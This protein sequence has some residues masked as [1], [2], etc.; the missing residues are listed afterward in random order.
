VVIKK[1][2]F[3]SSTAPAAGDSDH[4]NWKA[5]KAMLVLIPLLGFTYLITIAGPTDKLSLAYYVFNHVRALLLSIQGFAVTLPYCFLN[6]EIKN[7]VRSRWARFQTARSSAAAIDRNARRSTRNSLQ[8]YNYTQNNHTTVTELGNSR[9]SSALTNC[10]TTP[11]GS[12]G[13]GLHGLQPPPS[14]RPGSLASQSQISNRSSFTPE[15]PPPANQKSSETTFIE[16]TVPPPSASAVSRETAG[17]S[18]KKPPR[19]NGSVLAFKS[20]KEAPIAES[21]DADSA[22]ESVPLFA[23][24]VESNG[25][26]VVKD[27]DEE[28]NGH[29]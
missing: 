11:T 3:S 26:G 17:G 9:R 12:L 8:C 13:V 27:A 5:A 1:L 6:T 18:S 22:A 29:C 2:R 4:Q 19:T 20:L 24:V 28:D 21:P 7:V 15:P 23:G 16:V 10:R 25:G 14:P